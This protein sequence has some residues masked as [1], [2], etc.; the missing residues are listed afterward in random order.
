MHICDV[1]GNLA[2]DLQS[3]FADVPSLRQEILQDTYTGTYRDIGYVVC[4][5]KKY[6]WDLF[7]LHLSKLFS[8]QTMEKLQTK[9]MLVLKTVYVWKSHPPML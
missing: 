7:T 3:D 2:N 9:Q 4:I 8:N 1:C 5:Q 6:F